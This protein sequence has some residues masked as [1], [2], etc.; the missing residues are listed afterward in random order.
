LAGVAAGFRDLVST[1]KIAH[2]PGL[3]AAEVHGSLTTALEKGLD[4]IEEQ[5]PSF[6]TVAL[7]IGT[8]RSTY[9]AVKA[10]RETGGRAVCVSN[11]CLMRM[12][13]TLTAKEG[14]FAELASVAPLV[15]IQ[16]LR[17]REIIARNDR[18]VAIVTASGLKN[19]DI[20]A[21]LAESSASFDNVEDAWQWVSKQTEAGQQTA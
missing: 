10:L 17:E 16:H 18:V 5:E 15:A 11:D 9:Q 14:L 13:K 21:K 12:Q 1:G 19:L 6:E 2:I 7:S 3:V 20:S 4:W 8:T